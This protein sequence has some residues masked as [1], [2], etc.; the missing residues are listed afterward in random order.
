MVK[1]MDKLKKS[2]AIAL[3][4]KHT[5]LPKR[6][7]EEVLE[8]AEQALTEAIVEGKTI[9]L[10]GGYFSPLY[11]KARRCANPSAPHELIDV[12][13]SRVVKFKARHELKEATKL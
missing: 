11:R 9:P 5:T 7:I 2:E 4:A 6:T 10:L 12:P 1:R 8:A 3:V 13:A